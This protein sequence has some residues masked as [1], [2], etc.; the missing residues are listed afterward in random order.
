M[1]GQDK[2]DRDVRLVAL[3]F[4]QLTDIYER[5]A[6]IGANEAIRTFKEERKREH[7][8]RAD[9]RLRNTK[10]LL[11]NYHA[12]KEHAEYSVFGRAQMEESATDILESVMSIYEDG[13]II[14]SIKRSATR[15]AIIV[16]HIETM[17]G[18]YYAYCE[19]STNPKIN[20][21]RYEVLW[22]MYIAE[23]TLDIKDI[24]KKWDMSRENVYSDLKIAT[25]RLSAL[26]FGVDGLNVR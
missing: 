9:R 12:L 8:Y 1:G 25:E 21:R 2:K 15:T 13:V 24:A 16:S 14:E 20:L 6:E 3:T 4:E 7:D 22:D 18:L 23:E 10:L 17:L 11:R 19:K 5:A 26:I